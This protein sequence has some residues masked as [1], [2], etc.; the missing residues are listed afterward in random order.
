MLPTIQQILLWLTR[1]KY[2]VIF[3]L[4]IVE[5]PIL[6]VLTGFLSSLGTFNPFVA[7]GIILI[8]DV[9]GD[10]LLYGIGRYSHKKFSAR[11]L[12]L[13]KIS[14]ERMEFF[15]QQFARHPK[16]ILLSSKFLYGAGAIGLVTAGFTRFSFKRYVLYNALGSMFQVLVLIL[17][18]YYF[19]QAYTHIKTYLDYW[20]II[21]SVIFII[22]YFFFARYT[23]SYFRKS[24]SL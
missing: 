13:L 14:E 20:A 17:I 15:K 18:G 11:I 19:G 21:G 12:K 7:Y 4:A 3:P 1:Y 6:T 2:F 5:G 22:I 23:R 24:T 8:G 9:T 16:K 10:A